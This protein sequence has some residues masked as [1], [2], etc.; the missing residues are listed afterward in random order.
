MATPAN[1]TV[2]IGTSAPRMRR[3]GHVAPSPPPWDISHEIGLAKSA[4]LY[5]DTATLVSPMVAQVE[6]WRRIAAG[7]IEDVQQAVSYLD[8]FW[9]ADWGRLQLPSKDAAM[10][11]ADGYLSRVERDPSWIELRRAVDGGVLEIGDVPVV[12]DLG[13]NPATV[14]GAM[15][16]YL[17]LSMDPKSTAV[18]LLDPMVTAA[19]NAAASAGMF[20]GKLP[21]GS[22]EAAAAHHFIAK[23]DAFPRAKLDELLDVR[24][25][26]SGSLVA[27][28]GAMA[29]LAR[30]IDA[31]PTEADF[32]RH[33]DSAYRRV[34]APRLADLKTE[35]SDLRIRSVLTNEIVEKKG[36]TVAKTAIAFAAAG[37][38]AWPQ[39][40]QA[41][42]GAV[43]AAADIA[44]GSIERYRDLQR[45]RR[46]NKLL[47]LYDL[48]RRLTDSDT[49]P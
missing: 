44:S 34:V 30:E 23:I 15:I 39:L 43:V 49:H 25:E 47:W 35:T 46:A 2:S 8:S 21:A 6:Q 28:R 18:P 20:P 42:V 27:F 16:G 12:A 9:D 38:A 19:F 33:A 31:E 5:A 1:L 41:A 36:E 14:L 45:Q 29:D 32:A 24:K 11:L 7:D 37:A 22:T 26:L 3:G 4:L 10:A 40:A 17:A 48:E 13:F